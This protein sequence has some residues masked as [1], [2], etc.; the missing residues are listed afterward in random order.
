[1]SVAS[2]ELTEILG[3]LPDEVLARLEREA[4]RVLE[5][6]AATRRLEAYRPYPKQ[7]EFHAAGAQYR[8]RMLM[9]ANQVGKTLAAAME[10]ALHLTGRYENWE[11]ASGLEWTGKRFD[12]PVRWLAGSESSELTKKGVQRL[13]LGNPEDESSWGT[14]AIPKDALVNVQRR[15]S[16]VPNCV[17]AITVKHVSGGNSSIQLQ[18]YEQGRT[19]WQADTIDGIWFDEEPPEDIYSEGLTRTNTTLGPVYT[20]LTPLMGMSNVV[21]RFYPQC[22]GGAHLT[23]MTMW[24]ADHYTDEQRKAI[25]A[26]YQPYERDARTKGTPQLGSGR[27]FP[28]N[29]DDIKIRAFEIP[30]HWAQICGLDFGWGHPTA[31]VRMA[32]DRD[33]DTFYVVDCHRQREQTPTMFAASVKRWPVW[34]PWAWPQDGLQHDKGSGM[35]LAQQYKAQGLN[36]LAMPAQFPNGTNGVEAGV[37]E[38]LDRM[39]TGRLQVFEH[40]AP[41]FQEFNLYHRKDGIIVKLGDD[42]LSATRYAMMMARHAAVESKPTTKHY[43]SRGVV[44]AFRSGDDA[45]MAM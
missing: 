41:W 31:A 37:A 34:I 21:M 9:A 26:T 6:R 29:E 44:R 2:A 3:R 25:V 22:R 42:L 45:W 38:M 39:N 13:L 30:G 11:R 23:H 17:G 43:P 40:L 12:R 7:L 33:N 20:T 4:P 28:V 15:Q 14:G 8:E 24:D 10:T 19:K 27:V 36:L 1:M 35:Q 5:L 16:P 18:A 32:W